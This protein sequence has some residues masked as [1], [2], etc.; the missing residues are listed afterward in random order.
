MSS[1]T[2]TS[3]RR[4]VRAGQAKLPLQTKLAVNRPCDAFEQEADRMAD[5]VLSTPEQA[6]TVAAPVRVQRYQEQ[7]ADELDEAAPSVDRV[8]AGPGAALE[9][10]L[11]RDMEKRFGHD[12]SRV[13]IHHDAEAGRSARDVSA[14]AYTVGRQ[15]VFGAG[16]FTPGTL[17]GRRLLAHELTHVVQQSAVA[18]VHDRVSSSSAATPKL[19]RQPDTTAA[20]TDAGRVLVLGLY[21]RPIAGS[22]VLPVQ[23]LLE[24]EARRAS[25][26][27]P[28]MMG[29]M[30]ESFNKVWI[31]LAPSGL[32]SGTL[33]QEAL[34]GKGAYGI[35]AIYF[36]TAGVKLLDRF[37]PGT[38]AKQQAGFPE[39][40]F[41]TAAE[42]RNVVAA[43]AAGQHK[44]D[45]YIEHEGGLSTVKAG[46][47][48]ADGAALP[49]EWRAHLPPSFKTLPPAGGS[50]EPPG[51][52][53]G[54]PGSDE[55]PTPGGKGTIGAGG[56]E[57]EV[58][59][60]S[61]GIKGVTVPG[62]DEIETPRVGSGIVAGIGLAQLGL[63]LLLMF[64]DDPLEKEAIQHGLEKSLADPRWQARVKELQPVIQ[65]AK[66]DIYYNLHFKIHYRA[67][68]SAYPKFPAQYFVQS[69]EILEIGVSGANDSDG[70]K[71][72]PKGQPGNATPRGLG[73]GW[74]WDAT[75]TCVASSQVESGGQAAEKRTPTVVFP[76]TFLGEVDA[77]VLTIGDRL[78]CGALVT[79]T[80]S[81]AQAKNVNPGGDYGGLI[82]ERPA[83]VFSFYRTN[84]VREGN[85]N[86][87]GLDEGDSAGGLLM[88]R[89]FYHAWLRLCSEEQCRLD[90]LQVF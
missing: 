76:G 13:R 21:Q 70:G 46:S 26:L 65:Q 33:V 6:P 2:G 66:G 72:D 19:M 56:E 10:G 25:G 87:S 74:T 3:S 30:E 36:N 4:A 50:S 88:R 9:P 67:E 8:L 52:K 43:M 53:S 14:Q 71:L 17:E 68:K 64:T 48:T 78:F 62:G 40:T 82:L 89:E 18:G 35:R 57:I 90:L 24:D 80:S 7:N 83:G 61:P 45:L 29:G 55:T 41:Q 34:E 5:R 85:L 59:K 38:D 20:R 47:L 37:P 12:F 15:I 1:A 16:R 28:I 31:P 11:R 51:G 42:L 86:V 69:V 32:A 63:T 73:G 60:P 84:L 54:V 27:R 58:P 81:L 49:A 22:R 23:E 79:M 44:V 39:G 75:R 77:G